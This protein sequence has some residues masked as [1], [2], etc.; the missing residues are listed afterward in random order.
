MY[1]QIF[2]IIQLS[3][4]WVE[5]VSTLILHNLKLQQS[6]YRH[7]GVKFVESSKVN[8]SIKGG[9][10]LKGLLQDSNLAP[11]PKPELTLEP[12]VE[13]VNRIWMLLLRGEVQLDLTG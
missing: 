1:H 10:S 12:E 13:L 5:F 11:K 3:F 2:F 8:S 4:Y 6:L 7:V 9:L